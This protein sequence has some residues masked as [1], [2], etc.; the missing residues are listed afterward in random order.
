[1]TDTLSQSRRS[2]LMGRVRRRN[3]TPERAVQSCLHK[4]GFRFKMH[5][6]NLPGT[7][8]I[9]LPKHSVAIFVHGCF[10]HRHARC[11]KTTTPK[12][13]A[14]FWIAKFNA[15]VARDRLARRRL[16]SLGWSVVTIWECQTGS[17]ERLSD[18]LRDK[19]KHARSKSRKHY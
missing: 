5:R 8:D 9:V 15:N 10:W 1:M 3:T 13:R 4:L 18:T 12:T 19:L 7:P 16:R 2:A 11:K 6:S 14:D 17:L